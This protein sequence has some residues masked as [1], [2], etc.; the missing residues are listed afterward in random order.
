MFVMVV[1]CSGNLRNSVPVAEL[2]GDLDSFL[3]WY[4]SSNQQPSITSLAMNNLP[5]G[6]GRKGGVPKRNRRKQP[7]IPEVFVKRPGTYN[8]TS[9]LQ[10]MAACAPPH[11][12]YH[13]WPLLQFSKTVQ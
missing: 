10:H 3:Q 11:K 9:F 2:N 12:Q 4:K 1:I 5:A 6:R 13:K 8:V 7:T